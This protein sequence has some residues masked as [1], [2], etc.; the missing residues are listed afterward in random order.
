MLSSPAPTSTGSLVTLKKTE[1]ANLSADKRQDLFTKLTAKRQQDL[2]HLMDQAISSVDDL[3]ETYNLQLNLS[4][5]E[6]KFIKHDMSDV[7]TIVF[8]TTSIYRTT[9]KRFF[10]GK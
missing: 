3:Q 6:S 4:T 10:G 9:W 7:F 2:F 5:L 8:P 1:R